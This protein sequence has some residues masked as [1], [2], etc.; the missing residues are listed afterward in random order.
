MGNVVVSWKHVV[1]DE[2]RGDVFDAT[3]RLISKLWKNNCSS[4]LCHPKKKIQLALT[5]FAPWCRMKE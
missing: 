1:N 3:R 2:C 4:Q 5:C